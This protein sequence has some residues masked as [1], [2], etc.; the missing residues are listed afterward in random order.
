MQDHERCLVS[1]WPDRLGRES[2]LGHVEGATTKITY[3]VGTCKP[4][5]R[6]LL[7]ARLRIEDP[8][9]VR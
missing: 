2:D 1:M 7:A 5:A 9:D 3:D 4:G 8:A 6:D